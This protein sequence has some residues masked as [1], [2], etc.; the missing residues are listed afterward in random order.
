MKNF[1][2]FQEMISTGRFSSM[3][4]PLIF[5][6]HSGLLFLSWHFEF[7]P[8]ILLAF[9][10]ILHL[11]SHPPRNYN[12]KLSAYIWSFLSVFAWIYF[13]ISWIKS[14]N[15]LVHFILTFLSSLILTLPYILAIISRTKLKLNA[16]GSMMI[17]ISSWLLLEIV[18]DLN[19]LGFP[20][21]NLGHTL[22]PYPGMIQWYSI[23]G[24]I[25]GSLWIFI[26]NLSVF[27]LI[28][29]VLVELPAGKK[30]SLGATLI[31][32][33]LALPL[34]S[35]AMKSSSKSGQH[36]NALFMAVHT[37]VD[38]FD[39]KYSVDPDLLLKEYLDLT[40]PNLDSNKLNIIFWPENA[41]TGE[42]F[43]DDPE[44]STTVKMIREKLGFSPDIYLV[45]G[46][47]V[48]EKTD[49][50]DPG[51]YSPNILFDQEESYYFKRY[52]AALKINATD[53]VDIKVKKRLVPFSEKVPSS[54]IFS[55]L[56][57]IVPNLADLN[58]SANEDVSDVFSFG[59]E[60]FITNTIICYGSAFSAF[61]AGETKDAGST[62]LS[63]VL[64]EGWMRSDKAYRH[65]QWFAVCRAIEN[66]RP[67]IKSS[68]NG[69][70]AMI[71]ERGRTQK[72]ISGHNPG[73]IK[74]NIQT[75][76][77]PSFF[78][79]HHK[80]IIFGILILAMICLFGL[81]SRGLLS[82][83]GSVED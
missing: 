15:A 30:L 73:V 28:R 33:V 22:A 16:L 19:I 78:T 18:H 82:R 7:F 43:L 10:P 80:K 39:Y 8:F 13:T 50:P 5:I 12:E 36:E 24:T 72:F 56:V 49:P 47:I 62:F 32:I 70:S 77:V 6:L 55:P 4:I 59:D 57:S 51:A 45:T 9:L 65:F 11:L 83:S 79:Q 67:L 29:I 53:P 74:G 1:R 23:I 48:D 14:V 52:N 31:I 81:L 64:N 75:N 60:R 44:N 42:V 26:I 2:S 3:K 21:L 35:L 71:D 63:L 69:V 27:Y 25:G 37:S 34:L 17:F 20:Y 40:T 61:V 38:V 76:E 58:F 66:Q 68:N 41:L 46:A 54:R